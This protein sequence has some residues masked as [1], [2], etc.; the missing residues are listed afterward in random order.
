MSKALE[1]FHNYILSRLK[2]SDIAFLDVRNAICQVEK[3]LKAL[4]VIVKTLDVRVFVNMF[5]Q[6]FLEDNHCGYT[7]PRSTYDLLK[8]VLYEKETS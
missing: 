8:E 6:C 7:I 1:A 5:G 2:P 3:E 4:K